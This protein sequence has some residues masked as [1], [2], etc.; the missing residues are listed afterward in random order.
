MKSARIE[1]TL[2]D[3][4][5]VVHHFTRATS[6]PEDESLRNMLETALGWLQAYSS[7]VSSAQWSYDVHRARK[8]QGAVEA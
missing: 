5:T 3:G 2:Y 7:Q 4:D 1:V 6:R 8:A